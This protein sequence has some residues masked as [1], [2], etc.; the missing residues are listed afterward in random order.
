MKSELDILIVEDDRDIGE[1]VSAA[2][3]R[4][5]M[6][7]HWVADGRAMDEALRR[8]APD[9]I[10]LDLMLPGEDGLSIC[11]RLRAHSRVPIIMLTA[12]GEDIDRILGLELGA[13]DYLPKPFN[14]RELVARIRAVARRSIAAAADAAPGE[15][16]RF[17]RF[18]LEV[19]A[20]RLLD[21][22]QLIELSAGDFE[23]LRAFLRH[24]LR[25][26]SR[27]QLME[28]ARSR[29]WD[30][31][32]RSIDVAVVRLRRK[33]ERDPLHPELIKTVRNGGYLFAVPV[34]RLP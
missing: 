18:T 5:G 13:D 20:R 24:P 23:L 2:L 25:V 19:D 27:D 12:K 6:R 14:P 28:S 32:D 1:L 16:L 22:G 4:E 3:G 10:L 15:R 11:R 31:F 34:E 7:P 33:L 21:G 29:S 17:D 26:L 8:L 30:A 9:L